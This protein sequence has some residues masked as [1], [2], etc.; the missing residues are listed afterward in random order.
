MVILA[1]ESSPLDIIENQLASIQSEQELSTITTLVLEEL[2]R[3]HEGVLARY[4]LRPSQLGK[5]QEKKEE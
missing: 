2:R 4:E 5:W 1:P 3:I